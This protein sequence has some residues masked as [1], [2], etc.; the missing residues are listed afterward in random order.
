MKPHKVKWDGELLKESQPMANGQIPYT[1][2]F[3]D[4]DGNP[5]PHQH[6]PYRWD[7][8]QDYTYDMDRINRGLRP[9]RN[10]NPEDAVALCTTPNCHNEATLQ[11]LGK[12]PICRTCGD[13]KNRKARERSARAR[14]NGHYSPS[15][16]DRWSEAKR[17]RMTGGAS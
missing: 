17:K 11:L 14:A 6:F 10:V 2:H 15:I 16:M 4:A 5:L 7:N 9:E 12:H 13:E 8:E 3:V 1:F